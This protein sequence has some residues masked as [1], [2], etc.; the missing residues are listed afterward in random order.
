MTSHAK[1]TG[2]ARGT[3]PP[4]HWIDPGSEEDSELADN[5]T[6]AELIRRRPA[7]VDEHTT[8]R[9]A[10]LLAANLDIHHLPVVDEYGSPIGMLCTCDLR[11]VK[12][13]TEVARCM[14]APPVAVDGSLRLGAAAE[15]IRHLDLGALLVLEESQLLGL[16]TRGDLRRAGVLSDSEAP[17]CVVCGGRHHVRINAHTGIASC[18]DCQDRARRRIFE[19]DGVT[20]GD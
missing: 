7:V 17:R 10:E 12:P 18:L 9:T 6:V 13:D 15:K 1:P 20:G 16:V 11:S 4:L 19:D 2:R 14:S 3:Q 8:A 5:R